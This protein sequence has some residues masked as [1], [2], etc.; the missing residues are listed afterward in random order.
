[1]KLE[2]VKQFQCSQTWPASESPHLSKTYPRAKILFTLSCT[3]ALFTS[4]WREDLLLFKWSSKLACKISAH[5]TLLFKTLHGS[6]WP[7]GPRQTFLKLTQ[8]PSMIKPLHSQCLFLLQASAQMFSDL[9][10][11]LQPSF[12]G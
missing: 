9:V 12:R 2:R 3:G 10:H 5:V 7:S 6:L 8:K 4:Q 1:M 11:S